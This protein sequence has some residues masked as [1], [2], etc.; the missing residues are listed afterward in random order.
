MCMQLPHALQSTCIFT[1]IHHVISRKRSNALINIIHNVTRRHNHLKLS[2]CYIPGPLLVYSSFRMRKGLEPDYDYRRP[3]KNRSD[4]GKKQ[5][6]VLPR[7]SRL[8]IAKC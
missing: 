6:F 3:S 4:A 1:I 7:D 5:V 8:V 2:G